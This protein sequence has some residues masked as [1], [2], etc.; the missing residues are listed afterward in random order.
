MSSGTTGNPVVNPYTRAEVEQWG[1]VMARCYVAAG[2]GAR[3]V[4]Q[5]TASFGLFTGGFGF[6][7]GA[8]RIGAMVIPAGAGRTS[9]QL[10]VMRDLGATVLTGI[11]TYP[12]R[13]LGVAREERIRPRLAQAPRV[14]R[15][16]RRCHGLRVNP[17]ASWIAASAVAWFR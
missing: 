3:D 17:C 15:A 7:Y 16:D 5:I 13:I 8:E 1:A 4:I 9:L 11:S 6:H 12:P 2:V 14:P 10:Q